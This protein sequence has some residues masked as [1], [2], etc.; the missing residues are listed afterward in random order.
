MRLHGRVD[1]QLWTG[2]IRLYR[3]I[4]KTNQ[5]IVSSEFLHWFAQVF[6]QISGFDFVQDGFASFAEIRFRRVYQL[7][8]WVVSEA[9]LLK[10]RKRQA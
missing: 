3:K 10:R 9:V 7:A 2:K 6:R 5:V 4:E 8:L 1:F